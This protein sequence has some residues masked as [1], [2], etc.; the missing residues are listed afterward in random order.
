MDT[1]K[2]IRNPTNAIMEALSNHDKLTWA[3]LL[4]LTHLSK[5]ALSE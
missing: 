1:P 2:A 3:E 5:G 4:K